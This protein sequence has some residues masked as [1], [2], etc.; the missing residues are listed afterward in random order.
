MNSDVVIIGATGTVSPFRLMA[1]P[2]IKQPSDLKGKKAGITTFG[3]FILGFPGESRDELL[4]AAPFFNSLGIDGVKLHNLHVIKNTVLER[5]YN[6]GQVR[7]FSRDE[8]ANLV[9]DFLEMLDPRIVAHR[10]S[11]EAHRAITVAPDW[12]IDKLGVHN[13]IYRALEHRDTWQGKYSRR[14]LPRRRRL[15]S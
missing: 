2:E 12:S 11:G 5:I 15:R 6:S 4:A 13:A 8:Y 14:A 7:L 3:S 1:R 10:L 9:V